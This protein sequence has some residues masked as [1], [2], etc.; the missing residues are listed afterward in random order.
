MHPDV[1]EVERQHSPPL[2]KLLSPS[3]DSLGSQHSHRSQDDERSPDRML[4]PAPSDHMSSPAPSNHM[5]PLAPSSNHL[6]TD[7]DPPHVDWDYSPPSSPPRSDMISPEPEQSGKSSLPRDRG[8]QDPDPPHV[9]RMYHPTINGKICDKD[10]NE[11]PACTPPLPHDLDRGPDDWGP[12]NNRVEFEVADFLFRRNQMSAGDIDFILSLW[13]AS[14]AP[15][16]DK[17]PFSKATQMY[18]TIDEI[19]LGEVQWQSFTLQFNGTRPTNMVPSWMEG[20][21]NVWFRDPRILVHNL[22]SVTSTTDVCLT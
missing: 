14:L 9:I 22:L 8:Q 19:P 6:D 20:D 2:F 5:P 21:Y 1:L 18:H 15:H 4:S 16:N 3:V 10:G 12:F 7:V 17:P 13:A 11:L